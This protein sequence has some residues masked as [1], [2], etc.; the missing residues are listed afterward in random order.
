MKLRP[1]KSEFVEKKSNSRLNISKSWA[2]PKDV[3]TPFISLSAVPFGGVG[4]SGMDRDY[5][6]ASFETFSPQKTLLNRSFLLDL[7]LS[8]VSY[9]KSSSY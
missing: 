9:K 4:S 8:Y 3:N 2:K 5:G 7:K 6:Q 1:L